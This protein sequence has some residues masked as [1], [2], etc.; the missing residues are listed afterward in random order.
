[1]KEPTMPNRREND[2][3]IDLMLVRNTL[4]RNGD[5]VRERLRGARNGWRDLRLLFVLV[6]R[7]QQRLLATMPAKRQR[8]YE[9][10]GTHGQ[11]RVDIPGP[12][13]L[14][15]HMIVSVEHLAAVTQAA[16]EGSCALCAKSG[17]QA[18]RCPIREALLEMAPP[19]E[20]ADENT[21]RLD[22]EYQ[23]IAGQLLRGEEVTM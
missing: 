10:L 22:C 14:D 23:H 21:L 1:M 12:V 11:V 8:W 2:L 13:Q 15:R 19:P 17:R 16:M 9:E 18:L 5:A 3:M 20:V 7:T 6:N 4:A